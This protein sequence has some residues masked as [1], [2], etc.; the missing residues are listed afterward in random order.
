METGGKVRELS[1]NIGKNEGEKGYKQVQ[2]RD[3][4]GTKEVQKREI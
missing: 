3:K 4:R 2:K 1:V